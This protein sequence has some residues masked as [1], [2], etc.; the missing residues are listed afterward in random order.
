MNN[1]Q[2]FCICL[3]KRRT[4]C[5]AKFSAALML[6][7][8]EVTV[9]DAAL[10]TV[11]WLEAEAAQLVGTNGGGQRTQLSHAERAALGS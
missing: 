5:D 3:K 2:S 4:S 10:L 9:S 7:R 1:K 8:S 6:C 11:Q